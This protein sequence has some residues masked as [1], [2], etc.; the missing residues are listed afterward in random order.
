MV[1]K[2]VPMTRGLRQAGVCV[3]VFVRVL[4]CWL[5][6]ARRGPAPAHLLPVCRSRRGDR[7]EGECLSR[8]GEGEV[9]PGAVQVLPP[10]G[11]PAACPPRPALRPHPLSPAP[12]HPPQPAHTHPRPRQRLLPGGQQQQQQQQ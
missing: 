11:P 1:L 8:C 3:C 6:A 5:A 12:P 7:H 4:V 2:H 9:W 10:A